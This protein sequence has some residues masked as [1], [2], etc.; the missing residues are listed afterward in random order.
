MELYLKKEHVTKPYE[1][2]WQFCVG[3]CH[4]STLLRVDTIAMLKRFHDELGIKRVRFHGIFNDDL[5]SLNSFSQAFFGLPVGKHL[6]ETNFY[7]IGLVY[8]NILSIGM[9]PFVELSTMPAVLAQDKTPSFVYGSI[10][11]APESLEKWCDYIR[12]YLTYLFHRYGEDEVTQW[13]FELW[14]EPDL[15]KVFFKGTKETYFEFYSATAKTFKAFC[16]QLK[17]GGPATSASRWVGE[18]VD[19]CRANDVPLDFVT[20]HQYLGEAFIGVGEEEKTP[21]SDPAVEAAAEAE[22]IRRIDAALETIPAGTSFLECWRRLTGEDGTE[23]PSFDADLMPRNARVVKEQAKGL[24]VYY[25]EWNISAAF[26]SVGHDTRKMA[27]YD[28]RTALA[29]EDIIDGNSIWCYS[30]AFEELHQFKEPFHGGYGMMNFSGI[31]KPVY[32]GMKMLADA[33]ENRICLDASQFT[34]VEAAA[35]EG[36]REKQ[37]LLF[38]QNTQQ[39]DTPPEM[40]S[41][42]VE[43]EVCPQ[44]VYLQ[45][46]DEEHC[47]P[48][49]IW[50][51]MGSPDDLNKAEVA[52]I[53]E[54]SAMR[55][56]EIAYTYQEGVLRT[57]VA[58]GVN[59]LYFIRI[60]K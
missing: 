7:K 22:R 37:I 27:A 58:L 23:N 16:P 51:E 57:E 44:R 54:A 15:S 17:I 50:Q 41:I 34:E 13:Y 43:L 11:S 29:L 4:A 49:R 38:R 26:G 39:L 3:S 25:T 42:C 35:F 46:I 21:V 60:E 52:H 10:Q 8:D 18:F 19:W 24:P 56:E 55:D 32:H 33:E 40:V 59:D 14:N 12:A 20:T 6:I 36:T 2:K 9:Q 47:N 45:R 1:K 30:D 5:G 31:P 48:L 28:V 53:M